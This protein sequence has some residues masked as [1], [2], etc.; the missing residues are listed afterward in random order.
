M[1]REGTRPQR[2][3]K[4]THCD[5]TKEFRYVRRWNTRSRVSRRA[6]RRTASGIST[7]RRP[8]TVPTGAARGP[9]EALVDA[10]E[11]AEKTVLGES[12]GDLPPVRR[13]AIGEPI[14]FVS[15]CLAPLALASSDL[16]SGDPSESEFAGKA[17]L[18]PPREL[19]APATSERSGTTPGYSPKGCLS[20]SSAPCESQGQGRGGLDQERL[21]PS[22]CGLGASSTSSQAGAEMLGHG[23]ARSTPRAAASPRR[24]AR[25]GQL[26][27][28]EAKVQKFVLEVVVV[29][30]VMNVATCLQQATKLHRFSSTGSP[31]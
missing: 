27:A 31:T 28:V 29:N 19:E 21:G 7:A 12:G 13:S 15:S 25:S 23:A 6:R 30:N 8:A 20:G 5:P 10:M 1:T 16:A 18:R 17:V 24:D 9:A 22:A 2:T 26:T 11:D 14:E 4:S 3:S